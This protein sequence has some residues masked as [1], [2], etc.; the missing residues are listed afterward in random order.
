[1]LDPVERGLGLRVLD[2]EPRDDEC[3]LT[4]GAENERDRA[5]RGREREAGVV[6]DVVG[7]EEHGAVEAVRA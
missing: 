7:V 5:L 6:E 1:M 4:V 2:L 3:P